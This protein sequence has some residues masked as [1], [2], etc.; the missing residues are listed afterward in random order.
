MSVAARKPLILLAFSKS[1]I[2]PLIP[3]PKICRISSDFWVFVFSIIFCFRS[4]TN[5]F[6][7]TKVKREK[8]KNN[9]YIVGWQKSILLE[10]E[11]FMETSQV[12][13]NYAPS[14]AP[15]GQ[16]KTNRG[17]LKLILL[18]MITFGIYAIVVYCSISNDINV[19]AS[20][21]DGK[22]TMHYALLIF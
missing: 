4:S 20:R 6:F 2:S 13:G 22:K 8:K 5:R 21:Y 12:N 18:S 9:I 11:L 1:P 7:K 3:N 14:T 16:L 10:G 19:V 17:L 15:V